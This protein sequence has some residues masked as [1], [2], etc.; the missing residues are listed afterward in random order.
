MSRVNNDVLLE[1]KNL[2]MSFVSK[3]ETT[4]AIRDVSF[5][6][7]KGETYGLMGESGCGKSTVCKCILQI[8]AKTA[9]IE[10]GEIIYKGEDL[11]KLSDNQM[12]RIRGREIGMI[13]QEP[14]TSLNPVIKIRD[15][16]FQQFP[17]G[18]SREKK[19]KRAVELLDMVGIPSPDKRMNEYIHQFS[20][21]MR[22]RAMI[23]IVL[24]AEPKLL[25][26]DEPTTALDV[27]IQDQIIRLLQELQKEMD[28]SIILVTHDLGVVSQMCDR[29]GVMYAGSIMESSSTVEL[30]GR[31]KHPYLEGLIHSIPGDNARS[32][33]LKQIVGIPPSLSNLPSGCPFHPRCAYASDICR[34]KMPE[35]KEIFPNHLCRCH[36]ADRLEPMEGL[37]Q[38]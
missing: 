25:L 35:T 15:Q 13:F 34:E 38:L 28:M 17:A 21:G 18:W 20:G 26:A 27:T 31:P 32:G 22:Q 5:Q 14:M 1:V 3:V 36:L 2:N 30:F 8:L 7:K 23:A 16:I 29:I 37:I 19:N 10:S 12:N 9:V 24:A 33:R 4:H 11:L 6:V